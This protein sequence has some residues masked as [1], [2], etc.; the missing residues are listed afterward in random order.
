MNIDLEVLQTIL[1]QRAALRNSRALLVGISGIDGAGKGFV[2]VRLAEELKDRGI[3]VSL[4]NADGWLNL[5]SVR[6]DAQHPAEHFYAKAFRWNE[7]FAQL[8]DPLTWN[9]SIRLEADFTEETA[10]QYRRHLY[11]FEDIDVVLLEGIFLF[12]PACRDR[13]DLALWIDCSF[14]TALRRALARGQEGLPPDDTIHA[15]ETIYFPAQRIHLARDNPADAAHIVLENDGE[16]ARPWK[17]IFRSSTAG[18]SR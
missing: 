11:A 10:T 3:N 15:F 1:D 12:R 4:I 7:M 6:F 9:R 16:L 14:E 17:H 8:I 18:C 2:A 5:P 13:F